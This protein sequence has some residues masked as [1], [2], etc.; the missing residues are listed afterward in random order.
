MLHHRCPHRKAI[1][2]PLHRRT[3]IEISSRVAVREIIRHR[4]RISREPQIIS[5]EIIMKH[6]NRR[7]G[8][9]ILEIIILLILIIHADIVARQTIRTDFDLDEKPFTLEP[10]NRR[11]VSPSLPS[12]ALAF[13]SSSFP[14][15]LSRKEMSSPKVSGSIVVHVVLLLVHTLLADFEWSLRPPL[16][17]GLSVRIDADPDFSQLGVSAVVMTSKFVLAAEALWE[18]V[19]ELAEEFWVGWSNVGLFCYGFFAA[20]AG[21]FGSEGAELGVLL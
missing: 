21:F 12:P 13:L 6:L 4:H 16:L 7:F 15:S 5:S 8:Y 20:G 11:K 1:R 9:L 3:A 17:R 18:L 14:S 10:V 19:A 2:S